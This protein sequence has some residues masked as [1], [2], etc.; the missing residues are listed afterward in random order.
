MPTPTSILPN[1]ELT[2]LRAIR[3]TAVVLLLLLQLKDPITARDISHILEINYET[4]R[5]Y[6]KD[7]T[8]A[9]LV[10]RTDDGFKISEL[11]KS[12]L[13]NSTRIPGIR[14]TGSAEFPRP[15]LN[16][17]SSNNGI[18]LNPCLIKDTISTM[19]AHHFRNPE[20]WKTL[21][22]YG[23]TRNVRTEK[24]ASQPFLTPDY[25]HHHALLLER[26]GKPLPQWAGLLITILEKGEA[27]PLA[28]Y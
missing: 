27:I 3:K 2:F 19:R 28:G 7:L 14:N 17:N 10:T 20:I 25:I 4:A 13:N 26:S 1:H 12:K 8:H 6:L 16:N 9:S 11:G 18:D 5:N 24:L 22:H 15:S 23:I 21:A